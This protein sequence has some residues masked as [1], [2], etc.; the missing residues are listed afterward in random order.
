MRNATDGYLEGCPAGGIIQ[1][2]SENKDRIEEL[3]TLWFEILDTKKASIDTDHI[4]AQKLDIVLQ[5]KSI[6]VVWDLEIKAKA[7]LDNYLD[8]DILK[9]P[10]IIEQIDEQKKSIASRNKIL[11][12]YDLEKQV[13]IIAKALSKISD[14]ADLLEMQSYI[15]QCIENPFD[16]EKVE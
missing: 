16:T 1:V 10:E 14:D 11:A 2:F 12:R 8:D 3:K 5:E 6:V 7:Y 15:D 4:D 13:A 9:D